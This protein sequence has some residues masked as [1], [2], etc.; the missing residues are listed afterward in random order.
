M[1]YLV[2]IKSLYVVNGF[3]GILLYLPQ[4]AKALQSRDHARSLSLVTF[5]GWSLGSVVS[6]L[7]AALI[8]QDPVFTAVSF[9]NFVGAA[10]VFCL[11]LRS[12][13]GTVRV[14]SVVRNRRP[15][16]WAS[17]SRLCLRSAVQSRRFWKT[18]M[19]SSVPSDV[20]RKPVRSGAQ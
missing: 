18:K 1:S 11:A 14:L 2:T 8:V 16:S 7:Y 6:T 9:G 10:A 17:V 20:Q 13:L 15:Y 5:G 4:I 12:R 19:T 3:A